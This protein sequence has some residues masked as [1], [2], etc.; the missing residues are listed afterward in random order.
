MCRRRIRCGGRWMR[1]RPSEKFMPIDQGRWRMN[2]SRLELRGPKESER[3][4]GR[5]TWCTKKQK[6]MDGWRQHRSSQAGSMRQRLGGGRSRIKIKRVG[7]HMSRSL[8]RGEA[9]SWRQCVR[10]MHL[11]RV[12]PKCP[13]VAS[14]LSSSIGVFSS[15]AMDLYIE[16]WLVGEGAFCPFW[17]PNFILE[18]A[19]QVL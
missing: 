5:S 6:Y 3:S 13:C 19:S 15:F 1:W 7:G 12:G 17:K 9:K 4:H 14:Y 11:Q 10:S 2:E 16:G 8:H 18:W